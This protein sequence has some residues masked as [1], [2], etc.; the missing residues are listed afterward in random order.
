M[1]SDGG[2]AN[3]INAQIEAEWL[4][5][6]A[7][8]GQV[9]EVDLADERAERMT[10]AAGTVVGVFAVVGITW[11]FAGAATGLIAAGVAALT[12]VA[13]AVRWRMAIKAG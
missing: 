5:R 8:A 12:L 13:F 6:E 2:S 7:M 4:A 11:L 1:M 10:K 9:R 3:S